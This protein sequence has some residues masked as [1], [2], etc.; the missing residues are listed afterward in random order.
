MVWVWDE[1][2]ENAK[3]IRKVHDLLCIVT[4]TQFTRMN[5]TG[6]YSTGNRHLVVSGGMWVKEIA[7]TLS[8]EFKSQGQHFAFYAACM[9]ILSCLFCEF[10]SQVITSP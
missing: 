10:L 8:E 2:G 5:G 3:I 7:Q 4:G 6:H 1:G 9:Y